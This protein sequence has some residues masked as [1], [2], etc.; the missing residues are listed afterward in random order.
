MGLY[1]S[2]IAV[3]CDVT[4]VCLFNLYLQ[5]HI[6]ICYRFDIVVDSLKGKASACFC[7]CFLTLEMG[8]FLKLI[9]QDIVS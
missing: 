7:L 2:G 6:P 9:K 5:S 8:G 3:V 1:C 4:L